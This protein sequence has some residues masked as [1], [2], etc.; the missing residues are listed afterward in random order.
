MKPGEKVPIMAL[1]LLN[2]SPAFLRVSSFPAQTL[3]SVT[4][5]GQLT[6]HR[7]ILR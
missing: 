5:R 6:R 2:H 1:W 4:R 7:E 3:F